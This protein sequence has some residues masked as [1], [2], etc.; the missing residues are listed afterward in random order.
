MHKAVFP[1]IHGRPK[2]SDHVMGSTRYGEGASNG[3]DGSSTDEV[4]GR[5]MT[6]VT[7]SYFSLFQVRHQA[8]TEFGQE[9][10]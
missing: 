4:S 6:R 1:H 5:M 8:K 9:R 2:A 3:G 10:T 7:N